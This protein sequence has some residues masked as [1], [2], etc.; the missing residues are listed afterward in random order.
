MTYK[1]T[2]LNKPQ[3]IRQAN[4]KATDQE[5]TPQPFSAGRAAQAAKASAQRWAASNQTIT[6]PNDVPPPWGEGRAFSEQ[7][8]VNPRP[9][10][11]WR[12][13]FLSTNEGNQFLAPPLEPEPVVKPEVA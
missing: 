11:D 13:K 9:F 12:S 3:L 6:S 1:P 4:Q 2:I 5:L 8:R 7:L 10:E